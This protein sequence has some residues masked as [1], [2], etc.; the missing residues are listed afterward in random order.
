MLRSS[1]F[2][3]DFFALRISVHEI[4]VTGLNFVKN[5]SVDALS[6]LLFEPNNSLFSWKSTNQTVVRFRLERENEHSFVVSTETDCVLSCTCVR[7]LDPVSV[8]LPLDF[9]I[10][11]L[12]KEHFQSDADPVDFIFE[13]SEID[14]DKDD[15]PQV[16][17]FS[18][19]SID[20]GII[21]RDQIF[22][23]VPDYPQ[24]GMAK[25]S[26]HAIC[27]KS[28]PLPQAKREP[29]ENPFVKLLYKT[30]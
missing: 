2:H 4:G 19:K 24:C 22:L 27:N 21:L 12:E 18:D 26:S 28:L 16:G 25:G 13:S 9:S 8:S 15:N 17:Y 30:K 1:E 7:C 20:L 14:S 5:I 29:R 6:A 10:R 3:K 23:K 11:M